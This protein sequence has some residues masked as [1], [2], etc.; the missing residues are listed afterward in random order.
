VFP[1]FERCFNDNL[2]E[3]LSLFRAPIYKRNNGREESAKKCATKR[4]Y[5][6]KFCGG[7]V[8]DKLL[9]E[10]FWIPFFAAFIA[11]LAIGLI[12]LWLNK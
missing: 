12:L 7:K 3:V 8:H 4:S 5:N 11:S 6:S 2:A 10:Y 1:V 9:W